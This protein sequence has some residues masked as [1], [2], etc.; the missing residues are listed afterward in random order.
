L[1]VTFV[2][3]S[4]LKEMFAFNAC[5]AL[6]SIMIPSSVEAIRGFCGNVRMIGDVA[7]F[8]LPLEISR[9]VDLHDPWKLGLQE[10]FLN[11]DPL[12][13]SRIVVANAP[14]CSENRSLSIE[15]QR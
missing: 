15:F 11:L 6:A 2:S 7:G 14:I 8:N 12:S 1:I 10:H 4:Q 9:D 13:L 5:L 3:D